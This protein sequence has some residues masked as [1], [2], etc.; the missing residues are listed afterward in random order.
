MRDKPALGLNSFSSS[1]DVAVER[2]EK[3]TVLIETLL[4]LQPNCSFSGA[5]FYRVVHDRNGKPSGLFSICFVSEV[6]VENDE[7]I[8]SDSRKARLNQFLPQ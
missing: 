6:R 7:T 4:I 8:D 3:A 5:E 2:K 1:D